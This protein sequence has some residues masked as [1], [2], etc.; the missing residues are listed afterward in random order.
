MDTL[1]VKK[2]ESCDST[3]DRSLSYCP[4]CGNRLI[5]VNTIIGHILDGR[6]R[7][8][9]VLGRGGMGIVYRATHIHLDTACALKILHPELV[10]NQGSIERF[11]REARAAGRI[12]HPNAILVTDFG[13][14][15]ENVVYLVMELVHGPTLRDIVRD[16]GPMTLDE[17]GRILH[18]I[19]GAVQAAHE[20]GVI[21]RD[22]KPDNIIVQTATGGDRV[23]VLDFGIAK[24][25]ERNLA[26][27]STP[28]PDQPL[29]ENT[30]TEAGM[31]I[32]TPQYMSPEQCRARKLDPRS[33][34]YSLG[35]VLYEMLSSRLPY[36]G[37]TPIEIV[38]KQIKQDVP[39]IRDVMP[40]VPP[41]IEDVI[42][43]ALSKD[44]DDR[45]SSAREL[46]AAFERARL[47]SQGFDDLSVAP[48]LSGT[49]EDFKRIT[50]VGRTD[51]AAFSDDETAVQV[52]SL[53]DD[54]R[55]E[56]R[57]LFRSSYVFTLVA[58]IGLAGLAI[59]LAT[60]RTTEPS[61][62]ATSTVPG[63]LPTVPDGM[64][65]IEGGKFVMGRNN[66]DA[67]ER[68]EHEVQVASFLLD[69]Y[70]VTNREYKAFVDATGR[71]VPRHWRVNGS[72]DP[73]EADLPVTNVTWFDAH[74]Y[75]QWK[76]KRLPKEAEWEFTARSGAKGFLYPWGNEFVHGNAN[77]YRP[78]NA[79]PAPVGSY[80][81]DTTPSGVFDLGGNVSEWVDDH[82]THYR[83]NSVDTRYRVFRG[84]NFKELPEKSIVTYRWYDSPQLPDQ[85]DREGYAAYVD[86][87]G[88]LGFRC[89]SDVRR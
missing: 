66:G 37:E 84:G 52:I 20:S 15:A 87:Q 60:H 8:D 16:R 30:L 4:R 81:G 11:R 89:A 70:E 9:S 2:C 49:P 62:S 23:K 28:F 14:A 79:R 19:C 57:R 55:K 39:R 27:D 61:D 34:V 10:S 74:D 29:P 40:S 65:R 50:V 26:P 63:P 6:Y 21:H 13:V 72:Y 1:E 88:R 32:G 82:L 68:P 47:D 33:D 24:L 64:V 3:F 36:T 44:P 46:A 17:A 54:S 83:D 7:I 43:K 18:Q 48:T 53:R 51:E 38:I 22:L 78:G 31:L 77:V 73:A 41:Q 71:A 25:R 76:G 67:D 42:S 85:S 45:Y 35:I 12:Q 5:T 69:K 58:L 86:Q 56:R 80:A 59:Y 75:A